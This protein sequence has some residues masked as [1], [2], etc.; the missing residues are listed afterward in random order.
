MS[1]IGSIAS[2]AMGSM[3][4]AQRPDPSRMA[5]ELFAQLDT[6]GQGYIEKSDLQNAFA[7]MASSSTASSSAGVD[8]VFSKLDS[9]GDGKI[10]EDEMSSSLKKLAEQLHGQFERSRMAGQGGMPP[11]PPN[12]AG[13]SKDELQSQ[14][15]EIGSSDSKRA[16]LISNIVNNFDAADRDG[17]GKVSFKE[18]MAYDRENRSDSVSSGSDELAATNERSS[19]RAVMKRIMDL[20]HAYAS[21]GTVSGTLSGTLSATA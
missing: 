12:D 13:F 2:S 21:G 8:E 4:R 6:K 18:A 20:M 3:Q 7:Q 5:N 11:P 15:D 19:E 10:T 17:D 9:D 14:L 1:S 16:T